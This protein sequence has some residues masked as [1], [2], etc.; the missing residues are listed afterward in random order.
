VDPAFG[1][2]VHVVLEMKEC[3]ESWIDKEDDAAAT[4]AVTAIRAAPRD[5]F[6]TPESD[7]PIASG[8]CLYV[9]TCSVKK[10]LVIVAAG[11]G[12]TQ[13]QPLIPDNVIPSMK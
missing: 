5:K 13:T 2:L 4:P 3:I 8:A 7:Y 9:D 12:F 6:L 1:A 11:G 10:H